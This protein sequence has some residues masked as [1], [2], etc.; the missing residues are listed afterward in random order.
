MVGD[1]RIVAK[2]LKYIKTDDAFYIKAEYICEKNVA[3]EE[4]ILIGTVN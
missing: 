2:Q 3:L 1:G 4:K